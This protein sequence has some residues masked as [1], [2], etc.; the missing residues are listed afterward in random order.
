MNEA[1]LLLVL[2]ASFSNHTGITPKKSII[3]VD[4]DAMA[5]GRFHKVDVP[6]WG[7]IGVTTELLSDAVEANT[8]RVDQRAEIAERWSLWREEK[9]R[10]LAETGDGISSA[11]VFAALTDALPKDSIIAVDVGNNTYSF[12]RYFECD[13]QAVL[14]S[15][16]LGSIG[17]AYPAAMGAWAATQGEDS[18][19]K[20]R[21]VVAISGD[22]GF[23]QY[24][25]ELTTAVKYEMNITHVLL[26]NG[27]LGK[28]SKEQRA[29][30]WQVW[31]TSLH[32]PNFADY[33]NACGAHGIR[34]TQA[35]EIADAVRTALQTPGPS[36]IELITDPLL[37]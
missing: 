28:I 30:Q 16:Y 12:G 21:P 7:E 17:F 36:L 13:S 32:N 20:G 1:D 27:E 37:L 8:E 23:G 34:L 4:F 14:M 5:L 10:R 33:A 19:F 2:G 29:G 9:T 11:A 3:Q 24:L 22:G 15:G 6:V 31:Q 25:A 26:N 35:S 18:R